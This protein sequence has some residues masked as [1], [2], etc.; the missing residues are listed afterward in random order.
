MRQEKIENALTNTH[1]PL[2][3]RMYHLYS[4][5][6]HGGQSAHIGNRPQSTEHRSALAA[7]AVLAALAA[8]TNELGVG[9]V[10]KG[11]GGRSLELERKGRGLPASRRSP[12]LGPLEQHIE[13]SGTHG[14]DEQRGESAPTPGLRQPHQ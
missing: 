8:L 13:A 7:L 1:P 2:A 14:F 10:E 4:R 6:G 3:L 12:P 9:G 5:T 11:V